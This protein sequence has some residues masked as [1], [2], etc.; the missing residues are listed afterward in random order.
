M[1]RTQLNYFSV[2]F[3]PF[4]PGLPIEALLVQ[5][6]VDAFC[7][8][9]EASLLDGGFAMVTGEPGCGKGPPI[10]G[11][12]QAGCGIEWSWMGQKSACGRFMDIAEE[13]WVLGVHGTDG[14]YSRDHQV[15][16]EGPEGIRTS[17][18]CVNAFETA[19][20]RIL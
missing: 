15:C 18:V 20:T 10:Q 17:A 12:V 7:R 14:G 19:V 11:V 5:P 4:G 13:G 16:V 6:P 9:I 2:K 8:R 1:N 3:N